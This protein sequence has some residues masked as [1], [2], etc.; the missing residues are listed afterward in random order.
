MLASLIG[1][2]YASFSIYLPD[3]WGIF[4]TWFFII[5]FSRYFDYLFYVDFEASMADQRAQNA[6]KHLKVYLFLELIKMAQI[7]IDMK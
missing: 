1:V 2:A 7:S 3:S 6:L 5:S 4:F